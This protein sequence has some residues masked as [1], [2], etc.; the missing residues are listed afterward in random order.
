MF[1][2]FHITNLFINQPTNSIDTNSYKRVNVT[3]TM[4]FMRTR[5]QRGGGDSNGG[6]F[7]VLFTFFSYQCRE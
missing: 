6:I 4:D 5:A 3:E 2:S 7:L 1:F